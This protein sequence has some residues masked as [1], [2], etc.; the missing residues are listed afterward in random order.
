MGFTIPR[1]LR[2]E[3]PVARPAGYAR[4]R[5]ASFAAACSE[6]HCTVIA[7]DVAIWNVALTQSQCHDAC[8][9][10]ACL[11]AERCLLSSL[12][13]FCQTWAISASG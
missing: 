13:A 9:S 2:T 4:D 1:Y 10:V 6:P 3:Q 12:L 8:E 7:D 11:L 5:S